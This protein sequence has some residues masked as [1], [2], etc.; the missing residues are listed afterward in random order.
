[1]AG[2]EE[3]LSKLESILHRLFCCDTN[4]FTGPQGPQGP[5]G[6]DGEDGLQGPPGV[7]GLITFQNLNWVG[8]W[9]PCVIYNQFDA[10]SYLGSSYFMNCESSATFECEVPTENPSC[11]I[12][13][14]NQ[15]A[16]GP[17]GPTGLTGVSGNDGS[18]SGRW[19]F[20]TT[21]NIVGAPGS[22]YFVA[23]TLNLNTLTEIRVSFDD[24]NSTDY[25]AW[26]KALYDFGVDY[27]GSLFFI[28]ITEVGSN[29]IIGIY[30]LDPKYPSPV[31]LNPTHVQV[32]LDPMYVSNSVFT[33]NKNYTISWSIHGGVNGT[34]APKTK[35][36]VEATLIPAPFPILEYD[37]NQA[38]SDN[39]WAPA[40]FPGPQ[41][42]YYVAL[43]TPTVRGQ[44]LYIV[45]KG[46]YEFGVITH[47]GSS[48]MLLFGTDELTDE[49][50]IFPKDVYR[51]TWDGD[52]WIM[53][54]IQG[55]PSRFNYY[56][57]VSDKFELQE[58]IYDPIVSPYPTATSL[59]TTYPSTDYAIGLK[60]YMSNI[61]GGP[62]C[63]VK[64]SDTE[65]QSF[66]TGTVI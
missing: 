35:G 65:W 7:D 32:Y 40:P 6:E 55:Q 45:A 49:F 12:L 59:N 64:V 60:V 30:Q 14:A 28:Q 36:E 26:W 52:Y 21:S 66:S 33:P 17:Q 46:D 23:D 63:F 11:W 31:V 16:T 51:A 10:V 27:P 25:E 37:F 1:M 13:L 53:E 5:Q 47:D 39:P 54:I 34:I 29:N 58:T 62:R 41:F 56:R 20:L 22:T 9:V 24:I 18:N 43:P 50:V 15:G 42:L 61:P 38:Y 2:L 8:E 48:I 3:R 44:E 19:K 57:A 4:Q